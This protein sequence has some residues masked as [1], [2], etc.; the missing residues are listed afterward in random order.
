MIVLI[1][2]SLQLMQRV[3][4]T[5]DSWMQTS[6]IRLIFILKYAA[7]A[8]FRTKNTFYVNSS[9]EQNHVQSTCLIFVQYSMSFLLFLQNPRNN[10]CFKK[11]IK[12]QSALRRVTKNN[13]IMVTIKRSFNCI[14]ANVICHYNDVQYMCISQ[15]NLSYDNVFFCN[16]YVCWRQNV[17]DK[18]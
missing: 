15:W 11:V 8:C 6:F 3:I 2:S 10:I 14:H 16:E 1:K 4:S 5:I 18:L 13:G 17:S 12:F 7:S 9:R